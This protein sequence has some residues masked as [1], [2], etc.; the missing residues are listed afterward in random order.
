M[1][2]KLDNLKKAKP[3]TKN[4]PRI[5]KK[6]RPPKL[7][8]LEALLA[9]VLGE[10]KDGKT[11]AEAI[12]MALRGKATRGDVRAAEVLLD[13]AFGKV[14]QDIGLTGADGEKLFPEWLTNSIPKEAKGES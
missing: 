2:N 8:H 5:N 14:K 6:G 13:R 10:E 1:A 11:A 9:N 4:D 7:P 3:F 12:L